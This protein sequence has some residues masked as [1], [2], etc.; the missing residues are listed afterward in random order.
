MNG[1]D[2]G[3]AVCWST[4]TVVDVIKDHLFRTKL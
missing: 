4:C 2:E 3:A 1:K